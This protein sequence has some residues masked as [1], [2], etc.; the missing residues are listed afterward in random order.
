MSS[1]HPQTSFFQTQNREQYLLQTYSFQQRHSP[2]IFNIDAS[3]FVPGACEHRPHASLKVHAT[4]FLQSSP[5]SNIPAI[6]SRMDGVETELLSVNQQPPHINNS[7]SVIHHTL[8]MLPTYELEQPSKLDFDVEGLYRQ[9]REEESSEDEE[10]ETRY[11]IQGFY[12][13]TSSNSCDYTP[14]VFTAFRDLKRFPLPEAAEYEGQTPERNESRRRDF[15][16]LMHD[17]S[18]GVEDEDSDTESRSEQTRNGGEAKKEDKSRWILNP[19][20]DYSM[21]TIKEL[22]YLGCI[23]HF[24]CLGRPV[25]GKSATAPATTI[26]ILKSPKHLNVT[27]PNGLWKSTIM[28]CATQMLDPVRYFGK[29]EI[30]ETLRGTDLE[31]ACI[32]KCVKTYSEH[33]WWVFDKYD[34]EEYPVEL[35]FLQPSFGPGMMFN[36]VTKGFAHCID[37]V[38]AATQE[39]EKEDAVCKAA[40]SARLAQPRKRSGLG[41]LC[42]THEDVQA[43]PTFTSQRRTTSSPLRHSVQPTVKPAQPTAG[44]S[45]GVVVP[46]RHTTGGSLPREEWKRRLAATED[47]PVAACWADDDDDDDGE[48]N[49]V[50][51]FQYTTG[52]SLPREEWQRRLA[53]IEDRPI[54]A[55]WADDD[56]DDE[57]SS[58]RPQT[59]AGAQRFNINKAIVDEE[60]EGTEDLHDND[61]QGV[62]F[63]S[64][65]TSVDHS[66]ASSVVPVETPETSLTVSDNEDAEPTAAAEDEGVQSR[67]P[68]AD[69][70]VR[71]DSSP[72]RSSSTIT[73]YLPTEVSRFSSTSFDDDSEAE[74][75]EH[76]GE[77]GEEDEEEILR[78]IPHLPAFQR[79]RQGWWHASWCTMR[80][81]LTKSRPAT[82]NAHQVSTSANIGAACVE[83]P[84]LRRGSNRSATSTIC[85]L[86]AK[87]KGLLKKGLQRT[88]GIFTKKHQG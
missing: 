3:H 83:V 43:V 72:V 74:S 55:C 32:G 25:L 21:F 35:D 53:A 78:P 70:R 18:K 9:P 69:R 66:R 37:I 40:F 5:D 4:E 6:N 50:P 28:E 42:I 45:N 82:H 11:Y 62:S 54:A 67:P 64:A 77:G 56:D 48:E 71:F 52:G 29:R 14:A 33:G 36:G 79:T 49:V 58:A 88:K 22:Q 16:L 46:D 20:G 23:H 84:E 59:E 24:N 8:P 30:L 68:P 44:P 63:S 61:C 12:F 7:T 87:S 1:S 31:N 60:V 80:A 39:K 86:N 51:T 81:K 57:E 2:L 41:K 76:C 73:W 47:R 34:D 13:P 17:E 65:C 75:L 15:V 38:T 26:A 19:Q 10:P 27:T 85:K